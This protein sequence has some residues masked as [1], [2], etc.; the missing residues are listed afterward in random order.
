MALDFTAIDFETANGN[1]ASACAVAVVK[2]RDGEIVDSL[3]SLIRPPADMGFS[4]FNIRIHGIRPADVQGAPGWSDLFPQLQSFI[5]D[6]GL[7]AH[8]AAFDRGVWMG[9]S[10]AAAIPYSEPNFYCTVKLARRI[11]KLPSHRLPLVAEALNLPTF[12]HHDAT[13]DAVACALIGI[14]L[15]KREGLSSVSEFGPPVGAAKRRM[16]PN[17]RQK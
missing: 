10:E 13:E 6:D 8:N 12:R 2:V 15:S 9:T 14:E 4:S 7:V 1:R 11:L 5:G 17:G 16:T 3:S